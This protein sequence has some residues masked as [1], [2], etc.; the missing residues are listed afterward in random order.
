MEGAVKV[1]GLVDEGG[2]DDVIVDKKVTME[3]ESDLGGAG[4]YEV[5]SGE[6]DAG[7]DKVLGM[8]PR[9]WW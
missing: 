6:I 5:I 1:E 3:E 9:R 8:A 7:K 2:V 4:R